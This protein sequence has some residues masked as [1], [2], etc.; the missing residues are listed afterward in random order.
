MR[1]V[2][3][4]GVAAALAVVAAP[5][6]AAPRVVKPVVLTIYVGK[7]GAIG[8]QKTFT[9][10]KG[11]HVVLRVKSQVGKAVH[12]HGYDIEK[13]ITSHT[14]FV[15]IRVTANIKGVFEIEVHITESFAITVGHL[16]VK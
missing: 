5:A 2:A 13:P 9:V 8:G 1:F 6:Q 10:R 12:L 14:R 15:V 7:H 4:A 11:A 16:A 3:L